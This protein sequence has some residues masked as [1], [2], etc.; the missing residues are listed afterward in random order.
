MEWH[1]LSDTNAFSSICITTY[2]D[3]AIDVDMFN[4]KRA[5]LARLKLG[6]IMLND[7]AFV[8]RLIVMMT[9]PAVCATQV[10]VDDHLSSVTNE[11]E[12][13]Q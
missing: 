3:G 9:T 13:S 12:V 7:K 6:W 10:L 4:S 5:E 1:N 11:L 2:G 8:A